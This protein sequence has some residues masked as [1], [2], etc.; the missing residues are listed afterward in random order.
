MRTVVLIAPDHTS[1]DKFLHRLPST[2]SIES[3]ASPERVV[4]Q[5]GERHAFFEEDASVQ[6][7]F[8]DEEL[9]VIQNRFI[10]PKFFTLEFSDP[11]FGTL[12]LIHLANDPSILVDDDHG[13]ILQGDE[14]VKR[15]VSSEDYWAEAYTRLR[16]TNRGSS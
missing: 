7:D 16:D 15:L 3:S 10:A 2:Y 12:L 1:A 5:S 9:L 11:G 6:D 4:I 8:D 14:F 13:S